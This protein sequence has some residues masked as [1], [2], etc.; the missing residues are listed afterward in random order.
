MCA[1]A[2]LDTFR[3]LLAGISPFEPSTMQESLNPK[4]NM[5]SESGMS[6]EK[7]HVRNIFGNNARQ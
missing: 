3:E 6:K 5:I 1:P 7:K 2:T 4:C